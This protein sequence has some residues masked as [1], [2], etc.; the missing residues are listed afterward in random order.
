MPNLATVLPAMDH[1]DKVLSAS[2]DSLSRFSLAICATLV[3]GKRTLSKYYNKTWELD[4]YRITMGTFPFLI[5]N[6]VVCF[7][8]H[9]VLHPHYK[10]D[11]FKRNHWDDAAIDAAHKVVQDAYDKS[12][13]VMDI[14][15][16][17]DMTHA[18][19]NDMV[20][21]LFLFSN[22]LLPWHQI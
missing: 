21:H 19:G 11:Y 22:W 6:I 4:V 2:T 7:W 18:S 3:I 5:S 9:L 8:P 1:I 12:Y 20:S 13:W 10:L 16:D 17:E 14:E 15:G